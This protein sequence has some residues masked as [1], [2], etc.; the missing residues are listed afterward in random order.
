[1]SAVLPS[2]DPYKIGYID[3]ARIK[4]AIVPVGKI[5]K[6]SFKKF[7]EIISEKDILNLVDIPF[8]KQEN[9]VINDKKPESGKVLLKYVTS[10]NMEHGRYEDIQPY[11]RIFGVIGIMDC[12]QK[13]DIQKEYQKF[14]KLIARKF[15][16]ILSRVCFLQSIRR[17]KIRVIIN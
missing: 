6:K 17:T 5:K 8:I 16:T 9:G 2:L 14:K 10:H 3:P 15:S 4:I 11:R 7:I 13:Q 1:M 12:E